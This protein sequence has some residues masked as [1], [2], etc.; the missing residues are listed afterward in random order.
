MTPRKRLYLS[1]V[2]TTMT[3]PGGHVPDT[4]LTHVHGFSGEDRTEPRIMARRPFH[5]PLC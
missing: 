3:F 5:N 1:Y 4:S 2:G